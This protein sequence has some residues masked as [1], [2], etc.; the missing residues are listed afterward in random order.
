MGGKRKEREKHDFVANCKKNYNK[1]CTEPPK[2]DKRKGE[3][4][5]GRA[6]EREG[7]K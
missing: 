6:R 3:R 4:E 1:N 5:R 2:R 7:E